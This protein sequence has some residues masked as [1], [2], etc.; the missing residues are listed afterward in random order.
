[1]IKDSLQKQCHD[2][3]F[4]DILTHRHWS[5][6]SEDGILVPLTLPNHS[7]GPLTDSKRPGSFQG[8][9]DWLWHRLSIGRGAWMVD[10]WC[11]LMFR[12]VYESPGGLLVTPIFKIYISSIGWSEWFHPMVAGWR[13][14]NLEFVWSFLFIECLDNIASPSFSSVSSLLVWECQQKPKLGL[15]GEVFP[16]K[17]GFLFPKTTKTL[18]NLGARF[19]NDNA[20]HASHSQRQRH[21][22]VTV[23]SMVEVEVTMSGC[24]L[25]VGVRRPQRERHLWLFEVLDETAALPSCIA[26]YH[27]AAFLFF[28]GHRKVIVDKSLEAPHQLV[29][30]TEALGWTWKIV[31][32]N[33]FPGCPFLVKEGVFL[34]WNFRIASVSKPSCEFSSTMVPWSGR[35]LCQRW[36][37]CHDHNLENVKDVRTK[38]IG[39]S[40]AFHF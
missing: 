2:T 22:Q 36:L 9:T 12:C 35:W 7:L 15:F 24:T 30:Y 16:G 13:V 29:A 20:S 10:T 26:K 14:V 28:F 18:W 34:G 25:D 3:Y 5:I 33:F 37:F 21:W 8:C 27:P 19:N 11:F 4:W 17:K 38:T 39:L 40:G 6:P 32:C 23:T 31:V 1:M